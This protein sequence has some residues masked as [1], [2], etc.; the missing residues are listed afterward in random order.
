M[1]S[2][3]DCLFCKMI[4][5][6][7]PVQ[8]VYQDEHFIC[9]RDLHPQAPTHLLLIPKDHIRSLASAYPQ[10]GKDQGGNVIEKL[11]S[12]ATR[13]AHEQKLL[14]GGFRTVVNVEKQGGQTV[15]HLH[16]HILG[17]GDLKGSFG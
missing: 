15:F 10:G 12:I 17:G 14:P 13:I 6:D 4:R 7:I 2:E 11:F 16:L 8:P 1:K 9:I 5:G 3:A